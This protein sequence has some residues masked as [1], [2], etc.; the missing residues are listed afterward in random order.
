MKTLENLIFVCGMW[1]ILFIDICGLADDN[2]V[3]NALL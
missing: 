3:H 1:V 2:N